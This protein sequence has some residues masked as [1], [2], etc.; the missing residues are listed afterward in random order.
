MNNLFNV[1]LNECTELQVTIENNKLEIK[2]DNYFDIQ[3]ALDAVE[4]QLT[5]VLVESF[6]KDY[7]FIMK[8]E[9][10]GKFLTLGSPQIME[11][12][13]KITHHIESDT[14]SLTISNIQ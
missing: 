11:C 14:T 12:G 8:E 5:N 1:N 3:E 7:E 10:Y 13:W 4:T 9:D 2:S 6:P